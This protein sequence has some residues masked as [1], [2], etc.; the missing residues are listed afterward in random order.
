[1]T[2][3]S[4]QQLPPATYTDERTSCQH[5]EVS[6]ASFPHLENKGTSQRQQIISHSRTGYQSAQLQ[7]MA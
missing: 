2:L 6:K 4:V 3:V 5:R 7:V 1:M